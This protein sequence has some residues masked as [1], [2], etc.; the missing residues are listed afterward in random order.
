M[1]YNFLVETYESEILKTVNVWS[2][3]EDADLNFR[4]HPVD[5]R[6]RS[7]LE[8]LIHQCVSENIWFINM[9]DINVNASPLPEEENLISFMK[10]YSNDA[11]KRLEQLKIKNNSWWEEEV[12]FFDVVHS[13]AWILTRRIAH[14]SHH[15]GQLMAMLRMLKKDLYSNYGPTADTGGLMIHKA[16]TIYPYEN[17]ERAIESGAKPILP[18]KGVK[19]LTERANS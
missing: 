8:Q 3:F 7:V 11:N 6:G 13:R 12:S 4:P 17:I 14:T 15:R 18:E 16:P 2:Q 5:K 1:Q 10:E 9:F 19:P